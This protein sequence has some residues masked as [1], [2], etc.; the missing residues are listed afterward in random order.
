MK[1]IAIINQKGGV[2]KST[3]AVN[4]AY[5]LAKTN[6]VLLIDLDPQAHSC[7]IYHQES[8]TLTVRDLFADTRTNIQ[9]SIIPAKVKGENLNNLDI[10]ASNIH[11]AKT[12]EQ[13]NI[14]YRE[15]ILANHLK[16]IQANYNYCLLDCPPNLGIITINAL[17]ACDYFLIPL[18][19]DRGA[20]DGMADLL[21]T[22]QDIKETEDLSYFILR[23]NID[24]RNK[25]TNLYLEGELKPYQNKLLQTIIHRAEVINQA[26][27]TN[28]PI[29]VYAPNSK[30]D[31]EYK[32][33]TKEITNIN[34]N[35]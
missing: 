29:Q 32:S 13:I 18:T 8:T 1:T 33:L 6:K 28:Q 25:Q 12:T 21:K 11:L 22:A 27:I 19:A 16:K 4:L 10:I 35:V 3:I 15:K 30:S 2:G 24:S 17:Y 9:K 14:V 34:M 5:E 26:R 7:Q 31:L 23:N 20:L